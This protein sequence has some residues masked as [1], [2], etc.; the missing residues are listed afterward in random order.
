VQGSLGWLP[1]QGTLGEIL[2]ETRKRVATIDRA[3]LVDAGPSGRSLKAA[4]RQDCVAIIAE[5]KRR[6]PSKGQLNLALDAGS[7]AKAFERG[8]ASAIS[9]LTEPKHFGGSLD[10]LVAVGGATRLPVLKKDFHISPLQLHEARG[11]AAAVL[12]IARALPPDEL[13]LLLDTTDLEKVVEVRS[14][15]ELERALSAGAEIIGVNSRNLETLAIDERVPQRLMPIIPDNVVAIWESGI[16]SRDDV[17]RAADCGA[18]AVLVGSALS[19][20]S[21]P[22]AL[23]RSLTGVVRQQRHG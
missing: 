15:E 9:V 8:G 14:E 7:Q 3:S 18:D 16:Q 23:V 4:L 13:E 6:S 21:D 22:E 11:R 12:L 5:I 19:R 20:S 2:A 10:D 17:Q 1:P